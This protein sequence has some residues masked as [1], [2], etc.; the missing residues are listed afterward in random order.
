MTSSSEASLLE[1]FVLVPCFHMLF[2]LTCQDRDLLGW[3]AHFKIPT[4]LGIFLLSACVPLTLEKLMLLLPSCCQLGP[5]LCKSEHP[6]VCCGSNALLWHRNLHRPQLGLLSVRTLLRLLQ[7]LRIQPPHFPPKVASTT[8]VVMQKD[9]LKSYTSEILDQDTL[10]SPRL[11][12]LVKANVDNLDAKVGW[13]W[14]PWKFRLSQKAH[15]DKDSIAL[16]SRP[17]KI[18]KLDLSDLLLDDIPLRE[19]LQGNWAITSFR[20]FFRFTV[21]LW[22]FAKVAI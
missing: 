4:S 13:K 16:A 3:A 22:L 19:P 5:F 1:S 9:F 10:P 17:R 11:L 2:P 20:R 15:D 21:L 7:G 14:V 8:L 12:A 18:A 6:F